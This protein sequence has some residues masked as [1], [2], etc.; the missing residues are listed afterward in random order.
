MV[1]LSILS[2]LAVIIATAVGLPGNQFRGGF[3]QAVTFLPGIGLP[4]GFVLIFVLLLVNLR[5]RSR[6]SQAAAAAVEASVKP[7]GKNNARK[8]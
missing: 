3:W 2:F 6:E 5:R 4:A 7:V 1:G 8:K